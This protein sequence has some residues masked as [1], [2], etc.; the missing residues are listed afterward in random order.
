MKLLRH[1]L[2]ALARRDPDAA[3]AEMREILSSAR[4]YLEKYQNYVI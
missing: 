3:E 4:E 2:A 1:L